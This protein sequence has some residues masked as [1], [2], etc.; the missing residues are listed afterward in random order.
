M[1]Y[2]LIAELSNEKIFYIICQNDE[3]SV[4]QIFKKKI[5]ENLGIKKGKI[6]NFDMA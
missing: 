6:F 5:S 4:Y 1:E 3:K 2:K